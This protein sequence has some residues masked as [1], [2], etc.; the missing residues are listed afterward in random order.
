M[1]QEL[2]KL[3]DVEVSIDTLFRGQERG[4]GVVYVEGIRTDTPSY[5]YKLVS[6]L[7]PEDFRFGIAEH[8]KQHGKE[9]CFVVVKEENKLHVTAFK[10]PAIEFVQQPPSE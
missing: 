10:K 7:E 4:E 2:S 6:E 9:H 1:E 5:S 8:L 3:L